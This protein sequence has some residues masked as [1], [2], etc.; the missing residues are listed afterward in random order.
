MSKVKIFPSFF[1]AAQRINA[2]GALKA[3]YAARS[4]AELGN[5]NVTIE[6]LKELCVKTVSPRTFARWLKQANEI[7]LLKTVTNGHRAMITSEKKAALILGVKHVESHRVEIKIKHVL[8][9]NWNAY[10]WAA[11]QACITSGP[12]SRVKLQQI[13]GKDRQRQRRAE[14]KVGMKY[15]KNYARTQYSGDAVTGLIE[16]TGDP[17]FKVL[18]KQ[19][20]K[21]EAWRRTPDIRVCDEVKLVGCGNSR[22]I[23]A[24]LANSAIISYSNDRQGLSVFR[25]F[26]ENDKQLNDTLRKIKK[27]SIHGER[28][29][30]EVYLRTKQTQSGAWAWEQQSIL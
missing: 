4:L 17:Y 7:G 23:R 18:N 16:N 20:G 12:I 10:L 6:G 11:Q 1:L 21:W 28:I 14:K 13:T 25:L 9:K 22:N 8:G 3:W 5:D 19:S 15:T 29:P 2:V 27:A 26:C 24:A 30:R